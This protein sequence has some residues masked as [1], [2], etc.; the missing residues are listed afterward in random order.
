[1][2]FTMKDINHRVFTLI[3]SGCVLVLDGV[4]KNIENQWS[5]KAPQIYIDLF[6]FES[7]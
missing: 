5:I 6:Q 1:M 7:M 4:Q 3:G 2:F